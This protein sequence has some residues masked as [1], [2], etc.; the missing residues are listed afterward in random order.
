MYVH[1]APP[2][3]NGYV[4]KPGDPRRKTK[5]KS[6]KAQGYTGIWF[7]LGQY[8]EDPFGDKYSG[9]LGT[10]TAK[11]IPLA[12]YAP[13][14]EKTFFVYGG[15]VPGTRHL[16]AMVSW[17]DHR[18]HLLARP[19]VVCD[20]GG[21]DDPH[22]N[23]S[24]SIDAAGHLWIFVSGRGRLRPGFIYRSRS[25]YDIER[26][27]LLYRGE[28]TYPQPWWTG[29]D[30]FLHLF[31]MYTGVREL[32]WARS[33]DG[34]NWEKPRKL[35]GM[36]GHYQVSRLR[37]GRI[38]TAFNRHPRGKPDLRTDLYYLESP[39]GG[40]SWYTA[41]G[42]AVSPP[43]TNP[44]CPAL[45]YPFSRDRRLVYMKDIDLDA[46]GRPV[47][48]V[49]TSNDHRAGP[50][51]E[52]RIWTLLHW[53]GREWRRREVTRSSH[54][55]DMGSLYVGG[56]DQNGDLWRIIAPTEPGPRRWATGGEMALW[57]SEDSGLTWRRERIITRG[58]ASNHGYARRPLNAHPDFYAFWADGDALAWSP[59][60][61]YFTTRDGTPVYHMPE[62]MHGEVAEP[63]PLF[64]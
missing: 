4:Q 34:R 10:Y 47:I 45:V 54:N 62:V 60:R 28:F 9:G 7:S 55:Y 20:K 3:G 39:D 24:M 63:Q 42:T 16:Q 14:A 30:G 49:L 12:V 59:S 44:S 36:E 32:Y 31:T 18:A 19:T 53:D 41:D 6:R 38:I 61:L 17:Y 8:V 29:T 51:G 57:V 21:V 2:P 37:D 33:T 35:A 50:T 46:T 25:P 15:A 58:T 43:L 5:M 64:A 1:Y 11:H 40:E 48:L 13:D 27:E 22:D 56:R 26:F 52:P 23:P